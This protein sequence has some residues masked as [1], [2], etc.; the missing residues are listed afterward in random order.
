MLKNP[1][2]EPMDRID[3]LEPMERIDPE[4]PIDNTDPE[5]PIDAMHPMH[6]AEPTDATDPADQAESTEPTLARVTTTS[7]AAT[8]RHLEVPPSVEDGWSMWALPQDTPHHRRRRPDLRDCLDAIAAARAGG[9]PLAPSNLS[10][11]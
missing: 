10:R 6:R 7:A 1:P 3:P 4:D 9:R 5:D 2:A 8:P 11:L